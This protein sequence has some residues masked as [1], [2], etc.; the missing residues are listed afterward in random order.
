MKFYDK[1]MILI[2]ERGITRNRFVTDL[3]LN[4]N[5][6]QNWQKQGSKPR[7]ETMAQIAEYF[8]VTAESLADDESE[9]VYQPST[10]KSM[11][12]K[13]KSFY[14]RS[15]SLRGGYSVTD[16]L[17]KKLSPLL[18]ASITFLTNP[19]AG[20]YIPDKHKASDRSDIDYSALL[21]IFELSDRCAEEDS[22]KY[23]MIQISKVMLYR[24]GQRKDGQGN[25]FDLY[26]C[27]TLVKEKLDFLYTN[28]VSGNN[29]MDYGFNFTEIA[30]IK[31]YT[32]LSYIY[33]LSGLEMSDGEFFGKLR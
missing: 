3:K 25:D 9:L 33:L 14:Q 5:S 2:E 15:V 22:S 12:T 17:L 10:K 11:A 16:E 28:K 1:L 29:I 21:D 24:I 31:E 23:V 6:T 32:G 19:F 18:D 8:N 26:N 4:K 20:E 7:A 13:L 27:K 30:A